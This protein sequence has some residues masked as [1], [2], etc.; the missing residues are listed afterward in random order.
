MGHNS[1]ILEKK[2]ETEILFQTLVSEFKKKEVLGK[3]TTKQ[4]T[5]THLC[6]GLVIFPGNKVSCLSATRCHRKELNCVD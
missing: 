2:R 1:L 6:L 3:Q 4:K 5:A